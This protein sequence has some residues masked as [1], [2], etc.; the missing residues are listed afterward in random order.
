MTRLTFQGRLLVDDYRAACNQ[1]RES[2]T[3]ITG[4]ACVAARQRERSSLVMV[5]RCRH[6]SLRT[7]TI[8]AGSLSRA[9]LKLPGMR[10]FVARGAF[11]RSALELNLVRA[12]QG[13]MALVAGHRAVRAE[14][15]KFCF[16]VIEAADL[17]PRARVVAGLAS[18]YGAVRPPLRHAFAKL[19]MVRILMA[20]R[21]RLVGEAKR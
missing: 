2:V 4:D 16:R 18:K 13:L 20:C 1:L 6:P 5:K 10:V 19:S 9:V 15:G 11:L 12:G 14:K 8:P 21:A 17:A 3:F 7:V